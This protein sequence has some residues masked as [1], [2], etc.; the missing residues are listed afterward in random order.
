M[1]KALSGMYPRDAD[2]RAMATCSMQDAN[3]SVLHM[4]SQMSPPHDSR[5]F[6]QGLQSY[7]SNHQHKFNC[8]QGLTGKAAAQVLRAASAAG[9]ALLPVAGLL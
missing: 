4:Q 1:M 9:P 8:A 7:F 3:R 2:R 5:G 6:S